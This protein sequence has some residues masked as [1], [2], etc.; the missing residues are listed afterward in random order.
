[1]NYN[2]VP[3][4]QPVLVNNNFSTLMIDYCAAP[5]LFFCANCCSCWLIGKTTQKFDKLESCWGPCCIDFLISRFFPCYICCHRAKLRKRIREKY[6]IVG[7][8]CRDCC[9]FSDCCG[10]PA[11]A[12][13][14]QH[15][16]VELRGED[17][18]LNK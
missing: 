17:I 7:N 2:Q 9:I 5:E 12:L 18:P 16:E 6:G 15:R 4:S 13:V 1:M 14:Q 3:V 11:M 10:F 8:D